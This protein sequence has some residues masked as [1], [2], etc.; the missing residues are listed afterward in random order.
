MLD[1]RKDQLTKNIQHILLFKT[2]LQILSW[3]LY[4]FSSL[5][6]FHHLWYYAKVQME[7]LI[8]TKWEC[9]TENEGWMDTD[10]NVFLWRKPCAPYSHTMESPNL[11]ASQSLWRNV[12]DSTSRCS[13]WHYNKQYFYNHIFV[14]W[15]RISSLSTYF[16]VKQILN[17]YL[18]RCS[19]HY[20]EN[21]STLSYPNFIHAFLFLVSCVSITSFYHQLHVLV[22]AFITAEIRSSKARLL[23]KQ[24]KLI[25]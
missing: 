9:I 4:M 19:L 5:C 11:F 18:C 15:W 13:K 1:T 14:S 20:W 23:L 24:I 7:I 22:K 25:V 8:N 10:K 16:I 6:W 21:I 3:F 12:L 2:K 17:D